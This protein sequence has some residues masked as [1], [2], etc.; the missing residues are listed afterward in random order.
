MGKINRARGDLKA[1]LAV[2][3]R[4]LDV[5]QAAVPTSAETVKA[6]ENLAAIHQAQGKPRLAEDFARRASELGDHRRRRS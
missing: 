6:L 5:A 1:A 3:E 4:A 2:F